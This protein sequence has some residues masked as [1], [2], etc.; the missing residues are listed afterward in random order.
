MPP[1]K[2]SRNHDDSKSDAA[3]GKEKNGGHLTSTKMRRIA[4]QNS[5]SHT[6]EI[7]N[8]PAAAASQPVPAETT[9]PNVRRPPLS[10]SREA[11]TPSVPPTPDT[12]AMDHS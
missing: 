7:A 2:S 6:R 5:A 12:L 8:A 1:A 11:E 9:A 3:H 10:A 4:S